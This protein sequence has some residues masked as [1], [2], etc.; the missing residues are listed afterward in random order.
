MKR[1]KVLAS[2][3]ELQLKTINRFSFLLSKLEQIRAY[4]KYELADQN[5]KHTEYLIARRSGEFQVIYSHL[6]ETE[7]VIWDKISEAWKRPK[8]EDLNIKIFCESVIIYYNIKDWT[9][10]SLTWKQAVEIYSSPERNFSFQIPDPLR[11]NFMTDIHTS[12]IT[13]EEGKTAFY[14]LSQLSE[15]LCWNIKDMEKAYI[16]FRDLQNYNNQIDPDYLKRIKFGKNWED[17]LL[18][19]DC[20]AVVRNERAKPGIFFDS[21]Y[22]KNANSDSFNKI[23]ENGYIIQ[24]SL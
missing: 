17:I 12:L 13:N 16:L 10:N 1:I 4:R 23:L 5:D 7:K 6:T 8:L 19:Q 14:E 3:I 21:I 9:T 2:L 24:L 22:K 18:Y 20:L 11:R 15:K